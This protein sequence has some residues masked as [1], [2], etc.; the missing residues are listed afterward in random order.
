MVDVW[1]LYSNMETQME[2][3][4]WKILLRVGGLDSRNGASDE[5]EI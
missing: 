5:R 1:G 4:K 3:D 2:N